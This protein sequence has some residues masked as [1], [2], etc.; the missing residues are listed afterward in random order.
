MVK[1]PIADA[2]GDIEGEEIMR[3]PTKEQAEVYI[4]S[5]QTLPF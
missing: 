5:A 2:D 1:V 4:Q 3:F